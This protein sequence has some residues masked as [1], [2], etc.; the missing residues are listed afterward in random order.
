MVKPI[1]PFVVAL[2]LGACGLPD[3]ARVRLQAQRYEGDGVIQTCSNTLM[4]GYHI[5]FARF[6]A[7]HPF[8][9][10]YHLA[11]TPR[12]RDAAGPRDPY[13]Y[14]RPD[15]YLHDQY[16]PSDEVK[17]RLTGQFEFTLRDAQGQVRH[18]KAP[19]ATSIWGSAGVYQLYK[20]ELPL[21]P[22]R[23]YELRVSYS[24]GAVP[25]PVKEFYFVVDGCAF[26]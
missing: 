13:L 15:F 12:I 3:A 14:L 8:S 2:A 1:L 21:Q 19:I 23:R 7:S 24:P 17:A 16:I 4:G 9:A 20:S 26:Y 22:D 18:L 11:Y 5:D 10:V 6:D 25:P